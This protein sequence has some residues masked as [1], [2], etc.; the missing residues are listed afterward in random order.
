M[1]IIG[2]Y[3][4]D[5]DN[6]SLPNS[7]ATDTHQILDESKFTLESDDVNQKELIERAFASANFEEVLCPFPSGN[8]RRIKSPA[9]PFFFR[10]EVTLTQLY[11]G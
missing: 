11:F 2:L 9:Q 3:S 6:P 4:I 8:L 5:K 1:A 10:T 7:I